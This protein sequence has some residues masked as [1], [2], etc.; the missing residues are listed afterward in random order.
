MD[1]MR[2][3]ILGTDWWSDCDDAVALRLLTRAMRAGEVELIGVGINACA[4]HSAASLVGFLRADG[5]DIPV[6]IDHLATDF[7]GATKYQRRLAEEYA[8]DVKNGDAP[9]AV[10]LYR[11][12][13]AEAKEPVEIIEIGFLQVAAGV[14]LSGGDDISPLS[15]IELFKQKVSR[16]WVMAGRWD[17]DGGREHNFCNNARSREAGKVFCEL[18]PVPVT[19]LGFEVGCGVISGGRVLD[20]EDHLYRA[21]CDHGSERGRDSWDPMLVMLALIGDAE[22]AGY[23]LVRGVAT[24]DAESGANH[25]RLS[26]D[27][28]HAYVVKKFPNE[29]YEGQINS[30]L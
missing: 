30:R 5:I 1:E 7:S 9:D 3:F 14:L 23:D 19:F 12:L 21:M 6:G 26:P 22:R 29:Y 24:V 17:V 11:R 16:A 10:R 25:F 2:K 18:C 20:P 13:L 8:P 27:G 15:G 4:E 28:R